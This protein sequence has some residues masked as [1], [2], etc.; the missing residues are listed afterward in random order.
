[1]A[2]AGAS[3]AVP[4]VARSPAIIDGP[5]GVHVQPI[6]DVTKIVIAAIALAGTI[7]AML[8]KVLK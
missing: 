2:W 8:R 7:V 5:E 6:I 3:A 4:A 1:M